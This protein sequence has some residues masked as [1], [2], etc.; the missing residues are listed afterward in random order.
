MRSRAMRILLLIFEALWLSVV[1]PGH[2]RGVVPLP[3]ERCVACEPAKQRG[4]SERNSSK[5]V[6]PAS[7]C[8]ICYFAARLSPPPAI[9]FAP[10]RLQFLC[11][12]QS[13]VPPSR[14]TL[15]LLPTYDG[16]GPP[17]QA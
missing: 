16:R 9:Q 7:H 11:A 14:P 3:G 6:D 4:C 5:P 13:P 10:P 2:R 17:S 15:P 12:A 8:A 1:V